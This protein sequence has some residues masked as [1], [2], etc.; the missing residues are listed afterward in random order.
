[1]YVL[2]H[3][4][5]VARRAAILGVLVVGMVIAAIKAPAHADTLYAVSRHVDFKPMSRRYEM[6][7]SRSG[8]ALAVRRPG[9][10]LLAFLGVALL[11]ALASIAL[12]CRAQAAVYSEAELTAS[13]SF[14]SF[15]VFSGGPSESRQA[16]SWG[17]FG[18]DGVVYGTA[19]ALSRWLPRI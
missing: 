2:T 17:S 9:H 12:P 15:T 18:F 14:G 8:R 6:L 11:T 1:M 4:L 3:P 5:R 7:K 10:P 19:T 16:L 13:S